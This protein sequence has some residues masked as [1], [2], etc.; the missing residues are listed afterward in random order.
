[1]TYP[2]DVVFIAPTFPVIASYG[3]TD[4]PV[5]TRKLILSAAML[6]EEIPLASPDLRIAVMRSLVQIGCMGV[7]VMEFSPLS[8]KDCL[9]AIP[10]NEFTIPTDGFNALFE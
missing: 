10:E 5:L 2:S 7:F 3:G 9:A 8:A 1:M 6:A 4:W